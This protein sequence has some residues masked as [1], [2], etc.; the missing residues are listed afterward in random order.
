[1]KKEMLAKCK[2]PKKKILIFKKVQPSVKLLNH[3][4]TTNVHHSPKIGCQW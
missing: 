1:M 4:K 3:F 2:G